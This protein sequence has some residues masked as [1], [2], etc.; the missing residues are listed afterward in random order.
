MTRISIN[1]LP[2]KQRRQRLQLW[3]VVPLAAFLVLS[4]I[5]ISVLNY[6]KSQEL[7]RAEAA[8]SQV[9]QEREILEQQQVADAGAGSVEQL[10]IAI[11]FMKTYP[12]ETVPILDHFTA[13]LPERGFFQSF[14]YN[15]SGII[16]LTVQF[17][18]S[19]EAAYYLSQLQQSDWVEDAT[20]SSITTE[21]MQTIEA[22]EPSEDEGAVLPRYLAQYTIALTDNAGME[23]EADE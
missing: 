14:Q 13:R 9:Q 3:V 17:D 10:E 21:E 23:E 16:V 2:K 20:I 5:F 8:Y 19:R 1:L 15:E 11:E 4:T 7:N 18:S 12:I 22:E 6:T